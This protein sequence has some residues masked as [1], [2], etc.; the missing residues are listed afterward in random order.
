MQIDSFIIYLKTERRYSEHTLKAYEN[1]LNQF[2]SFLVSEGTGKLKKGS[3]HMYIRRWI[4]QM[5]EEGTTPVTVRRKIS[6]LASYYRYQLRKGE[7]ETNPVVKVTLPRAG[8]RLP[9]F[10]PE[11]KMNML[12]DDVDFGTDYAGVRD[13]LIIEMLWFT[14]MRRSELIRLDNRD[15]DTGGMVIKVLGKGNKQRYVPVGQSFAGTIREYLAVKEREIGNPLPGNPFFVTAG[16]KRVY[17]ELV[18]RVVRNYLR[19]IT[20]VERRGPHMLRHTFATHMLNHGADLNAIKELLGHA[21]LAATQVYTHNSFE[22]LKKIY[23]QA[24]PRA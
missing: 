1:D 8:R 22:K 23:K 18:Y 6:A 20:T 16:N 4:V 10:I 13:R 9:G 24:H 3:E 15:V 21:N 11:E 14:G 7:I 12:L 5:M 2:L 19:L 17:P